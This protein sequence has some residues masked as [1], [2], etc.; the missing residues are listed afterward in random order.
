[1]SG[2]R[3]PDP[4]GVALL[5]HDVSALWWIAGGWAIELFVG[6]AVREHSDLEI[7][8]F[9]SDVPAVLAPL[10]DWDIQTA[11]NRELA[12]FGATSL[13]DHSAFSL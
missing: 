11:R 12:P 10:R 8:C 4:N 1:M 6:D 9:R 2:W 13:D 3:S 7:G 5:L